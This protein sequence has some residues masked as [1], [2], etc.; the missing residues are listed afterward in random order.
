MVF[1][2][3]QRPLWRC[4]KCGHSFVTR[5]LW[6]S[7]GKYPLADHFKNKPQ[8]LRLAFR[9]YVELAKAC[10]PVTVYAQ[11]TRIVIQGRVRFAGAIVHR[12]WLE[13]TMWLKHPADHRCLR[14]LESFGKLGFGL[15][16]CLRE[17]ADIDEAL[18]ELM[19]EAY[20]IGEQAEGA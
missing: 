15:H 1:R 17:P 4:P 19:R 7:C 2:R 3:Q 10:G 9:R 16:F 8:R 11:K 5:N 12:D 6:H 20:R 13:A 14:R 18:A